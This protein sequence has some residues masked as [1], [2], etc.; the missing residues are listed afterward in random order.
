MKSRLSSGIRSAAAYLPTWLERLLLLVVCWQAAG[1]LWQAFAPASDRAVLAMPHQHADVSF[2]P[3]EALLRWYDAGNGSPTRVA[4]DFSLVAVIAGKQGAAVLK[5]SDGVGVAM[6]VGE[7]IRPGSRLVAVDPAGITIE[8][9]GM[10][11][12]IALPQS[13]ARGELVQP[14]KSP[15]G[16]AGAAKPVRITRGQMVAALR[17]SNVGAW[18]AGLS[19]APGGGIRVENV[20]LQPFARLLG[21]ADGDVLRSINQRPLLQVAD[22][23]LISHYF[24]QHTSVTIDLLRKGAA[25]TRIYEIQ[26]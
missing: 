18:D 17:E 26:P 9:G 1:V 4:G 16:G 7:E 2:A 10:R 3:Q 11:Q 13:G 14:A 15:A 8:Q 24:G 19:A 23:S 21:F 25:V 12:E 22:I 20:S 5:G 6:R